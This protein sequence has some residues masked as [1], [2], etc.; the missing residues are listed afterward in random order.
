M[1]QHIILMTSS[2][3]HWPSFFKT[4]PFLG[5]LLQVQNIMLK[6]QTHWFPF[7]WKGCIIHY[8]TTS[9]IGTMHLKGS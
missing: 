2:T 3:Q 5:L 9:S 6:V 1:P 7:S 4:C 8:E